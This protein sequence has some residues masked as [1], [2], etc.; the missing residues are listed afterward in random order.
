MNKQFNILEDMNRVFAKIDEMQ[1]DWDGKCSCKECYWNMYHPTKR[2][3]RTICVSESL[4]DTK[5]APN[6]KECPSYWSYVEAVGKPKED[7]EDGR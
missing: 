6:S 4:S 3:D 2:P 7:K 5:M 1:G